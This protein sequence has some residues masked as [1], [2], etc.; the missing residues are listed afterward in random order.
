MRDELAQPVV[1]AARVG[2]R[3]IRQRSA[4]QVIARRGGGHAR[5]SSRTRCAGGGRADRVRLDPLQSSP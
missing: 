5:E 4:E 3:E 2:E 1:L